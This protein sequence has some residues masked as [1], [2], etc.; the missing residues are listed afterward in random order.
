MSLRKPVFHVQQS[1]IGYCLPACAQM[2]L[3]YLD[4]EVSQVRLAQT[5]GARPGVGTPFS[6]IAALSKWRV[7]VQVTEWQGIE[8]VASALEA[9]MAGIVAIITTPGLPQ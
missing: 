8:Q 7:D 4:I 5:M 1:T 9:G 2:A 3:A 6:Q